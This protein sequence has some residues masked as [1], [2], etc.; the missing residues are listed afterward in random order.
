MDAKVKEISIPTLNHA[1]FAVGATDYA[2]LS[3]VH[4]YNIRHQ[5]ENYSEDVR[6]LIVMGQVPRA[7]DYLKA[8]QIR[9]K[10]KFEFML[11][12]T[13]VDVII[14]P[15]VPSVTPDIGA[16][17]SEIN[18]QKADTLDSLTRFTGSINLI[19]SPSLSI[20]VGLRE[21]LPVGMQIIGPAF[22][23]EKVLQVG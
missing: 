17:H 2:E 19:G 18:G 14:S 15:A 12:F 21:G 3:T 4:D 16:G 7:V 11:L 5:Q 20:P 1:D 22:Q 23:E 8:Q 13:E 10:V 6:M 9:R